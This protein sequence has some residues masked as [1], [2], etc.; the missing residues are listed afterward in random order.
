MFSEKVQKSDSTGLDDT[1]LNCDICHG[2]VK[3][4]NLEKHKK[5]HEKK[6]KKE[7]RS[8]NKHSLILEN[9]NSDVDYINVTKTYHKCAKCKKLISKSLM[10]EHLHKMH[11]IVIRNVEKDL[12]WYYENVVKTQKRKKAEPKTSVGKPAFTSQKVSKENGDKT[13]IKCPVCKTTL[14]QKNLQ[15]HLKKV[16]GNAKI[17]LKDTRHTEKSTY[18]GKKLESERPERDYSEDIFDRA[19]IYHGGAYGLGK[20][21]KH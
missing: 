18:L 14:N 8:G 2:A 13:F 21:R 1:F 11:G 5:K 17:P 10:K 7:A 4:K 6:A 20:N 9:K 12:F 15:K 16:H 19:I 3:K